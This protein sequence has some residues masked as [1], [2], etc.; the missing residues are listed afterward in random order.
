M[1][2]ASNFIKI[3]AKKQAQKIGCIE[4]SAYDAKLIDK[5]KF[6]DLIKD[7]VNTDLKYYLKA[8][9]SGRFDQ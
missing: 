6:E 7:T 4:E 3:V 5:K 8:I 2:S 1:L 9:L